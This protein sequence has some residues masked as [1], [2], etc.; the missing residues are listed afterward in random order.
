MDS[1]YL[2]VILM[3][4]QFGMTF[5]LRLGSYSSV[6]ADIEIQEE[7]EIEFT[8]NFEFLELSTKIGDTKDIS[9]INLNLPSNEWNVTGLELNLTNI[10]LGREVLNVE[11]EAT[12]SELLDKNPNGYGVQINIIE[13]TTIYAVEIFAQE[14]RSAT[15]NLFIQIN[16]YDDG[17]N[18]PNSTVYGQTPLN[19]SGQLG[20]YYQEFPTGITLAPDYYYLILNG[21]Q[22]LQS[23]PG[24]YY[25]YYSGDLPN[26][27]NYHTAS[28][29]SGWVDNGIGAPF[30]YKLHQ[31]TD[32]N[33]DPED[34]SMNATINGQKYTVL[35]G[36][37]SGTGNLTIEKI[38]FN[39]GTANFTIPVEIN[40]TIELSFHLNYSL[41][42]RNTFYSPV[43]LKIPENGD[44]EW[45]ITPNINRCTYN[46]TIEFQ[47]P[48][49]WEALK[50]LRDGVDI[51]GDTY[52]SNGTCVISNSSLTTGSTWKITAS[53][54]PLDFK[55]NLAEDS[56]DP[57][58]EL[59]FTVEPP[60]E[61]GNITFL[62]IDA[63]DT[64]EVRVLDK[65]SSDK[66]IFSYTLGEKPHEGTWKIYTF[67]NDQTDAGVQ[68]AEIEVIVPFTIPIDVL[69]MTI[70]LGIAGVTMGITTYTT[71]KRV[72]KKKRER[73]QK[74]FDKYMDALNLGQIIITDKKSGL[75]VYEQQ[76]AGKEMDATLITGFLEAIRS[77]GLEL[78]SSDDQTQTIKL[79]FKGS[80]VL[81]TE[82]KDF[83]I[84]SVMLEPPSNLFV[85][86]INAL[87][88]D[89]DSLYGVALRKFKGSRAEFAGIQQLLEKHL[90]V[91]LI[92]PLK[93]VKL[94][95]IKVSSDEKSIIGRARRLMKE[96]AI[97]Y[98]FVSSLLRKGFQ[99]ND[100]E[101]I[102]SLIQKKIFQPI[103]PES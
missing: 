41:S 48:K 19:I 4:F 33:Y 94:E 90:L 91:S 18:I 61:S 34:L 56:Y 7:L 54:K 31:K 69:I 53:S 9:S 37:Q 20:W 29:S 57:L 50:I 36:A 3:L 21:T 102:L 58:E 85:E 44:N 49:S 89:I 63:L 43:D 60:R 101:L 98:F 73:R 52:Q 35:N 5:T 62:L 75:D 12:G 71:I 80:R 88:K 87:S 14:Y 23:D 70:V 10:K 38:N 100:A 22:M 64:E 74:I 96:K 40:Q 15:A 103:Y 24:K 25:W 86:S 83:R 82:Y 65:V 93:I 68:F 28:Y 32:R 47:V 77:F 84:I 66:I 16:G 26:N 95:D 51:T 81:M 2:L 92:Y 99:V 59:K 1:K 55:L 17:L 46:Y 67:W 8:H 72:K 45:S 76:F 11:T 6:L 27:S 13:P 97:K 78:T 39:P 42:I 79:D 30:L